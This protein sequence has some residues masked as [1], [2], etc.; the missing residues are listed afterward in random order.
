L[1][2][3]LD[4]GK[5]YLFITIDLPCKANNKVISVSPIDL[6]SIAFSSGAVLGNNFTTKPVTINPLPVVSNISGQKLNLKTNSIYSYSLT[7]LAN[8]SYV[9]SVINGVIV[10]GQGTSAVDVKWSSLGNGSISVIGTNTFFCIDTTTLD[11]TIT[12]NSGINKRKGD[13]NFS[14]YPNPNNGDFMIKL[15]SNKN[16]S[17]NVS[18]Y[19]MLGQVF[20][21]NIYELSMGENE[22][23]I[24]TKLRPGM[25]VLKIHSESEELIEQVMIR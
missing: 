8:I 12:G 16:S 5:H 2:K 25:Y 24:S 13:N 23:P 15:E 3:I 11:V 17:S 14:I 21:S 7:Q 10:S 20:W 18:L 9:W 1:N 19:N 22:I 4:T 6:N